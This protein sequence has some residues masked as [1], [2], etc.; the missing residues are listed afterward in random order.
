M[1]V[2]RNIMNWNSERERITDGERYIMLTQKKDEVVILIPNKV[3]YTTR[4]IIKY[5]SIT[6]D[7]GVD[8]PKHNL[9][10]YELKNN[11]YAHVSKEAKYIGQKL[12]KLKGE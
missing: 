9:K 3:N 8:S 2:S 7:K 1:Y 5:R 10:Q 6:N 11:M 12:I 4:K